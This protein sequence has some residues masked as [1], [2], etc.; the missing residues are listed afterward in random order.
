MPPGTSGGATLGALRRLAWA[1][2]DD[3]DLEQ[4]LEL[5]RWLTEQGRTPRRLDRHRAIDFARVHYGGP[6]SVRAIKSATRVDDVTLELV[7]GSDAGWRAPF[8]A[9]DARLDLVALERQARGSSTIRGEDLDACLVT[10]LGVASVQ[11]VATRQGVSDSAASI[12]ASRALEQLAELAR[13]GRAR[14]TDRRSARRSGA[15]GGNGRGVAR[16]RVSS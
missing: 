10:R 12:R 4:E 15:R 5:G 1:H 6:D 9:I 13:T 11:D 14:P 7:I 2:G 3:E 8:D 16:L